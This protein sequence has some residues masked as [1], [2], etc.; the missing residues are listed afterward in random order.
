VSTRPDQEAIKFCVL[1]IRAVNVINTAKAK[2]FQEW[3]I[4]D[5]Q[6]HSEDLGRRLKEL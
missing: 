1:D 6:Y 2:G 3:R 5:I 4:C